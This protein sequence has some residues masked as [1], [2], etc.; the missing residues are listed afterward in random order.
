MGA[1]SEKAKRKLKGKLPPF[2]AYF[3]FFMVF[4]FFVFFFFFYLRKRRCKE[5]TFE[6]EMQKQEGK[7][8]SQK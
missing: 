4:F 2:F 5:K 3:F 8:E 1:K 7:N 6:T